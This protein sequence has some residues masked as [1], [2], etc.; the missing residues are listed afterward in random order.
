M[1]FGSFNKI[2]AYGTYD[3]EAKE[4]YVNMSLIQVSIMLIHVR[5]NQYE[6]KTSRFLSG[7]YT[8]T[9]VELLS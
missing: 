1:G 5:I 3:Y 9:H 6:P 4:S 2:L 7:I 8:F